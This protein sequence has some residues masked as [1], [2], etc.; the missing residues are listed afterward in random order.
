MD[1]SC[2]RTTQG[3]SSVANVEV[4]EVRMARPNPFG[5]RS[6]PL[7]PRRTCHRKTAGI[8]G[9]LRCLQMVADGRSGRRRFA[10]MGTE[11]LR[12]RHH[13]TRALSR[14]ASG[15]GGGRR[16]TE[17]EKRRRGGGGT[18][19]RRGAPPHGVGD[20]ALGNFLRR[21]FRKLGKAYSS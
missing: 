18:P 21:S 19:V 6:G 12:R 5:P 13:T 10:C 7:A 14:D 8:P 15:R 9:R 3:A 11:D 4:V 17:E 1:S 20:V 16:G 2:Y